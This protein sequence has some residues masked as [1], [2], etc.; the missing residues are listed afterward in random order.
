[1]VVTGVLEGLVLP[2]CQRLGRQRGADGGLCVFLKT[3]KELEE[4]V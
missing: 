2:L 3:G 1:M 4:I